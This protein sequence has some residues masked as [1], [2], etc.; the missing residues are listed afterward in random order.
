MQDMALYPRKRYLMGV[1]NTL[2]CCT[3][4]ILNLVIAPVLVYIAADFGLDNATAGYAS[5]LHVLAQG[6]FIL[7]SPIMMA[8]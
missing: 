8:G 2:C 6:I 4:H 7:I 3:T 1:L 5:T